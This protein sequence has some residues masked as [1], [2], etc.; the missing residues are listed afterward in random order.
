[1]KAWKDCPTC[2]GTGFV[3][4][5]AGSYDYC[6]HWECPTCAAHNKAVEEAVRKAL[7]AAESLWGVVANVSDGD[8]TDQNEE[9]QDAAGRARDMYHAALRARGGGS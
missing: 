9:W 6:S 7:D 5:N 1:M 2:K 3:E 8:W 4:R